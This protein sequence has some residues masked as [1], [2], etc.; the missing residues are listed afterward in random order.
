MKYQQ[1]S[2]IE[3]LPDL[4]QLESKKQEIDYTSP[5][6]KFT[7]IR[8]KAS[9]H[10][11]FGK[12]SG[13]NL[14]NEQVNNLNQI[15][16]NSMPSADEVQFRNTNYLHQPYYSNAP[17]NAPQNAYQIDGDQII[18]NL[19]LPAVSSIDCRQVFDHISKCPICTRFY[20]HDNTIYI[21]IIAILVITCALLLKKVLHV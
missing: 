21:I 9:L 5:N 10:D 17:Q 2:F 20:K 4:E 12:D 8:N 1:V 16:N 19:E 7:S 14:Y 11:Q 6:Y 3:N 13:M 18:E 15:S